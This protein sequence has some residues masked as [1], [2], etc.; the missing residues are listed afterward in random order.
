MG[1]EFR[2]FFYFILF[3]FFSRLDRGRRRWLICFAF[4]L[5][6]SLSVCSSGAGGEAPGGENSRDPPP[7]PLPAARTLGAEPAGAEPPAGSRAGV[8]ATRGARSLWRPRRVWPYLG[9]EFREWSEAGRG[10]GGFVLAVAT[11]QIGPGGAGACSRLPPSVLRAGSHGRAC[12]SI[13]CCC[14]FQVDK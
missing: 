9:P 3:Y 2:D 13:P 7:G 11:G 14:M 12:A 8:G 6:K 10:A 5:R 1:W 4:V